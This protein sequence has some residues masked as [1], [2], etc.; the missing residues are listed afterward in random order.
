MSHSPRVPLAQ[1]DHTRLNAFEVHLREL[2]ARF[3]YA[4]TGMEVCED[5]YHEAPPLITVK[6][7][8]ELRAP[9]IPQDLGDCTP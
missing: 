4:I 2:A 8:Q 6:L 3:D 1:L 7:E 9:G 5:R